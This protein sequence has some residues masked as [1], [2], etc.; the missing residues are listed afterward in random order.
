MPDTLV[1]SDLHESAW[2]KSYET[3]EL[4][5]ILA[6]LGC[7]Y[8]ILAGIRHIRLFHQCVQHMWEPRSGS[9]STK[10]YWSWLELWPALETPLL[11]KTRF[12]KKSIDLTR[13]T[14]TYSES[15]S[16]VTLRISSSVRPDKIWMGTPGRRTPSLACTGS[17]AFSRS[18]PTYHRELGRDS[19]S[20]CIL[21]RV[22]S[23][24]WCIQN[25]ININGCT[26]I[27]V[28]K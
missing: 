6:L 14:L 23:V 20:H 7:W 15:A 25:C 18:L 19:S 1:L 24:D 5:E 22:R 16:K 11:R 28:V 26:S 27:I 8:E 10:K 9:V 3:G 2:V 4:S 21:Y 12:F 13:P 17:S